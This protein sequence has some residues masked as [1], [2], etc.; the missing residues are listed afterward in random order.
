MADDE[1]VLLVAALIGAA[2]AIA[3]SILQSSLSI[4]ADDRRFSIQL[5]HQ[6][7]Q[8][9]MRSLYL[10]VA[11]KEKDHDE[12]LSKMAH[13]LDSLDGAL[14]PEPLSK[15]VSKQIQDFWGF[16]QEHLPHKYPKMS[17]KEAKQIVGDFD[18]DFKKMTPEEQQEFLLPGHVEVVRRELI[19]SIAAYASGKA[20][21]AAAD[22]SPSKASCSGYEGRVDDVFKILITASTLFLTLVQVSPG[23]SHWSLFDLVGFTSISIGI[24]GA[25]YVMKN[26]F[27]TTVKLIGWLVWV[28]LFVILL[29]FSQWMEFLDWTGPLIAQIA[30]AAILTAAVFLV[31]AI[32]CTVRLY[33]RI[34][35]RE[36]PAWLSLAFG[37]VVSILMSLVLVY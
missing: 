10:I 12:W 26:S 37:I 4:K 32:F 36:R 13:F 6:D 25:G 34:G 14:L 17:D 16:E 7:Q 35:L 27:S 33:P 23:L 15:E 8:R 28:N 31:W 5:Y 18:Q 3:G 21:N 9:A 11:A 1:L 2:A 30:T 19:D 29:V 22:Q 24:W 20:E